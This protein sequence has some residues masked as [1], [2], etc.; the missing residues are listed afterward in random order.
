MKKIIS[1]FALTILLSSFSTRPGT[2]KVIGTWI[3]IKS[4]GVQTETYSA[5]PKSIGSRKKIV[6]TD[7]GKIITYKNNIEI[8]TNKYEITKGISVFDNLEHDLISFE[9]ITYAI[10][11]LD[12]SALVIV[13]N[14]PKA[15]RSFYKKK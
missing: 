7:D 11:T 3:W 5:T 12:S 1:Y 2:E 14:S 15:Y 4:V 6:F 10:E 13:N 9:G 8:R